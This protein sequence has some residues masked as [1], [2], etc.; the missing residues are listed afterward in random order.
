MT[1]LVISRERKGNIYMHHSL[2][3]CFVSLATTDVHIPMVKFEVMFI[4]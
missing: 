4:S 1:S 3:T 2:Q